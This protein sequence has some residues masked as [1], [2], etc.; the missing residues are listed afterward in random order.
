V[1]PGAVLQLLHDAFHAPHTRAYAICER[2]VNVLI[3][4]SVGLLGIDLVAPVAFAARP[5]LHQIDQLLLGLLALELALRIA[6]YHPGALAV[7]RLSPRRR[8]MVHVLDRLRYCLRPLVLVDLLTVLGAVPAMRGLR[9]LRLLR[10]LRSQRILRYSNPFEGIARAVSE[11]SVLYAFGISAFGGT[12]VLGAL[13]F[14]LAE[15]GT[16][17]SIDR[18]PDALWWSIV[19][20]TS[21]GYGDLTPITTGGRLIAA[22]LM[23][24]GMVILA[25]FAGIVGSSLMDT[26][27]TLRVE[28]FRMS[29]TVGHVLVCGY[30]PGFGLL[31][32]ALVRE[33]GASGREIVLFS[34]SQ[35]PVDV[36]PE[37]TWISG[38]P[39]KESELGKARLD[40]A[41]AVI[42]VGS[43]SE[44]P[45]L[46]DARTI[47]V[48]F[49]MRRWLRAY[50]ARR[51][52]PV[53]VVAEILD[54]ENVDHAKTAGADE[55]IETRRIGFHLLAHAVHM[56]G[57]ASL[58]AD[59]ADADRHSM[60]VGRL[61]WGGTFAEVSH[62]LLERHSVIAIGFRDRDG[63]NRISP[64]PSSRLEP[65]TE[66][67][68]VGDRVIA[69]GGER[70]MEGGG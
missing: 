12:V 6:T 53:Y 59:L 48:I 19:T 56:P 29:G 1:L 37:F 62:Q 33:L 3:A 8:L 13:A 52:R 54:S 11:N 39:T 17:P 63:H 46:A 16:N 20:I 4:L 44:L 38:D 22:V 10:L 27:L 51:Q 69:F 24:A 40:D 7:R 58:V 5:W 68:Y 65:G 49:T 25:L 67:L 43:R 42:V 34:P 35:R 64:P 36:P 15:R 30:E 61:P 21:V 45:Q 41:H 18:V 28:A 50:A 26:V 14:Y 60:Y 2:V 47:L 31:L 57:T 55:V 32:E 70:P 66:V 23:V 9:A